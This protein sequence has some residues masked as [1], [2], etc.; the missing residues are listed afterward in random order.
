MKDYSMPVNK[1]KAVAYN[2]LIYKSKR[3][4]YQ[5]SILI[6]LNYSNYVPKKL[7]MW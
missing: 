1:Y 6:E 3:C 5:K 4:N 2:K 7:L